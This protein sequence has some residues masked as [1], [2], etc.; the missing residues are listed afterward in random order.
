MSTYLQ[1]V[2]DYIP[3]VQPFAPDY[4]FYNAALGLK[5]G[6]QDA[7]RTKLSNLYGSLLNAPL[8]REDNTETRTEFFKTIEQDIHKMAGM[9]LTLAQNVNSAEQVFNQLT[10]NDYIVKD[11]VWTRQ[12]QG[13]QRRSNGFKNCADP[14]K[15]GG[16]WWEGGDRLLDFQRRAFKDA[17]AEDSLRIASPDYIPSQDITK[18]MMD[19]AKEADL[20][21]SYDEVGGRWITTTKN[22]PALIKP[23]SHLFQGALSK[24]PKVVAFYKAQGELQ[25]K[26]FMYGHEQEYGSL[27]AAENAYIQTVTPMLDAYYNNKE[28]ELEDDVNGSNAKAE[29][30]QDELKN[31]MPDHRTDLEKQY[32]EV[33][34][35]TAG[36]QASLEDVNA[37]KDQVNLARAQQRYTGAQTDGLLAN[38]NLSQSVN[39][40]AQVLS[41][42][43]YEQ[44]KTVN[45]YG[46]ESVKMAN[47]MAMEKERFRNDA[48]LI[49]YKLE[50]ES[51]YE[52]IA[53]KGNGED[54]TPTIV[55]DGLAGNTVINTNNEDGV[56]NA[57]YDAFEK[58][59]KGM[60]VD[61]TGNEKIIVSEGMSRA[62]QAG[63]S[64]D[65]QAQEDYVAMIQS[66][67]T[68]DPGKRKLLAEIAKAP[69]MQDKFNLAKRINLDYNNIS[70]LNIENAY[71]HLHNAMDPSVK[72]NG[73]RDY[74][75]A[76]WDKTAG[77][78]LNIEAKAKDIE[79]LNKFYASE[80]TRI[81]SKVAT[82]NSYGQKMKDAFNV[83]IDAEGEEVSKNQFIRG[84]QAKG[85][86]AEQATEIW[87]EKDD[88]DSVPNRWREAFSANVE[89]SGQGW[90]QFTGAG[91]TVA[92][93][94]RYNAVDPLKYKSIP[95]MA[96]MSYLK[97]AINDGTAVFSPGSFQSE[98]PE[99]NEAAQEIARTIY[100]DM[101]T[102][103]K[104][105]RPLLDVTYLRVAGGDPNTVALR[106]KIPEGYKNKYQG[107]EKV[108]KLMYDLK[109]NT[110]T[111][112]MNKNKTKDMFTT[113][114]NKTSSDVVMDW[115]G[116]Y[117]TNPNPKYFKNVN[118]VKNNVTGG[119]RVSGTSRVGID[120]DG[121]D[122][123]D[124]GYFEMDAE[125]GKS[126]SDIMED[127]IFNTLIR[128]N[129]IIDQTWLSQNPQK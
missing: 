70:N 75:K 42:K 44:T 22:G 107:T 4:N 90:S 58:A 120:S 48:A 93:G 1:G 74:Y 128:R 2:T 26:N 89:P 21:V 96:T 125:A 16:S 57:A 99:N 27:E 3:Q 32:A 81:A 19:L 17:S 83:Y 37:Q 105:A 122:I 40:M 112:Y 25:R 50:Q 53:I 46:L 86:N 127:P 34:G 7:A 24:D 79:Q 123:W 91:G 71:N 35:Q 67:S 36:Y 97:T 73:G 59:E 104:A 113:G 13:Q 28:V 103:D 109:D 11:M 15:C 66:L 61:I 110:I 85:Y 111:I 77:R 54:N 43:G 45:P 30:L 82:Q 102:K 5:Q 119:Y 76:L 101:I 33:Q 118:I 49:K 12:F 106:V 55:T 20:S 63:T 80:S 116:S 47:K 88:E 115:A 95:T 14:E 51:I 38:I 129:E 29:K 6:K 72:G 126:I 98:K 31:T 23:L 18:R 9:D 87:G 10:D 52:E 8:T 108:K 94:I 39:D 121:H 41:F 124:G 64:G 117:D 114:T 60:E 78:R 62:M 68:D 65:R 69:K 100:Q 92:S 56:S 84:M